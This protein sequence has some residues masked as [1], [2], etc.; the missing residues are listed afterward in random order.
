[1]DEATEKF[2]DED[3]SPSRKVN[4]LDT[5]GSHFYLTLYWAEALAQQSEH[6]SLKEK[7]TPVFEALSENEA[8]IAA[9]LIA[10]QGNPVNIGGYYLP[11]PNLAAEAMRPSATFNNILEQL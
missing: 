11:E 2:L 3:K 1:M 4:E 8:V 10:A 5:R 9:E 7:F 6:A